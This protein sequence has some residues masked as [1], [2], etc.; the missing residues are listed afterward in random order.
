MKITKKKLEQ[1]RQDLLNAA[2][3]VFRE[4][5]INGVGIADVCK[6]AVLT[7]GALYAH[8]RSKEELAAAALAD[9]LMKRDLKISERFG[10]KK[11]ALKDYLD[12]YLSTSHRD[13]IDTGCSMPPAVSEV[14]RHGRP[15]SESFATGFLGLVGRIEGS[16]RFTTD[17]DRRRRALVIVS[18]MI[19]SLATAR[20]TALFDPKL[21]DEILSATRELLLK[22]ET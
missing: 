13:N 16:L 4:R 8:F 7:H 15:L 11:I 10:Q 22:L 5:G 21:S 3:H 2:S 9:S 14:P 19:G 6:K 12:F 17:E 20:A 18:A 1:N